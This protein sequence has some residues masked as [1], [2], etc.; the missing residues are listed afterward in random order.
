M[1]STEVKS[2]SALGFLTVVE[3]PE[4][5]L[6]GGYLVLNMSGALWSSTVRH[7]SG[8]TVRN[9]YSMVLRSNPICLASRSARRWS[10]DRRPSRWWFVPTASR[11]SRSESSSKFPWRWYSS[12]KNLLPG[13]GW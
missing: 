8:P 2:K 9:R 5:G 7:R 11:Y 10:V 12:R 13:Q 1:R 6:F 4:Q 3:H